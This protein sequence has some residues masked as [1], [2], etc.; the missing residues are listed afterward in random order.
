MK[1]SI[2]LILIT[3][4]PFSLFAQFEIENKS[5]TDPTVKVLYAGFE[6]KLH[7]SQPLTSQQTI[8]SSSSKIDSL[9]ASTYSFT[10][11]FGAH[12]DTISVL[13][14]GIVLQSHYYR[15]IN[16]PIAF[17]ELAGISRE[18]QL[19]SKERILENPTLNI[20]THGLYIDTLTILSFNLS[21]LNVEEEKIKTFEETKGY[22][23]T[24]DQLATIKSLKAGEFVEIYGVK[25]HDSRGIV[26]KHQGYKIQIK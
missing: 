15:I 20:V 18:E 19:V 8:K 11:Q 1:Y 2:I 23:L 16:M 13:E 22:D 25:V 5:L 9:S 12:I 24:A 3:T 7:L 6:N 26:R 14:N 17:I 21:I 10:A 4:L